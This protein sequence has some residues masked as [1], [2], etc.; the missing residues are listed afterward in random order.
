MPGKIQHPGTVLLRLLS[1]CARGVLDT[2]VLLLD[3]LLPVLAVLLSGFFSTAGLFAFD[4]LAGWVKKMGKKQIT[5]EQK[6]KQQH[7][8]KMQCHFCEVCSNVVIF[9]TA[10]IILPMLVSLKES[11][12]YWDKKS[13]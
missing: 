7:A 13:G 9:T 1:F 11:K 2:Q 4:L 10:E 8:N 5:T 12:N 6:Q 3:C